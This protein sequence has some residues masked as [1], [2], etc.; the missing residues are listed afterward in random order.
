MLHNVDKQDC[1]VLHLTKMSQ[2]CIVTIS[3]DI[4]NAQ[5]AVL[6]P[7]GSLLDNHLAEKICSHHLE[8]PL[9]HCIKL[10][11]LVT[12]NEILS[13]YQSMLGKLQDFELF[14]K[15]WTLNPL[16]SKAC[17]YYEQFPLIMQKMTVLKLQMP[18][19]FKAS[20][21]NAYLSMAIAKRLGAKVDD[22][23]AVFLAGL[24][25]DIGVLHLDPELLNKK[26]AY[27]PEEWHNMQSHSVIA[28]NILQSIPGL[29]K[30]I[31]RAVLEH[32][33]RFDGSGYP[34]AKK[35][36]DLGIMGQIVGMADTCL[37]LYKRELAH[38]KLG[39]DALLPILQL[40]PDI[41]CRKVFSAM[42]ELIK[43]VSWPV[44]RVYSDE[45]IPAVISRL[46]LE[47]EGIQHD[48]TVLYGL[49]ASI[50]P[51]LPRNKR[52][53]MLTNMAQRIRQCLLSSGILQ[54]EHSQ[55]MA[56]SSAAQHQDDYLAIERL[57]IMYSEIKW[58]MLQ[59]KKMLFLLWKN[60]IFNHDDLHVLVQKG[61]WQ[62]EQF[63]KQQIPECV[64]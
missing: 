4:K 26:G 6:V 16:L 49:V 46:L 32:H 33:E 61:L 41:Y 28:F 10:D 5:G 21:M 34:L 30:S 1:Y 31:S 55:W 62:I 58:Q 53:A 39:F 3:D 48:Y 40:N 15:R 56:V 8:L 60:N 44:K 23:A 35:G 14:H 42:I 7:K 47:N 13:M 19:K 24:I 54:R 52:S 22:C 11:S 36:K 12:G 50:R 18:E 64:H 27:T 43:D 2:Q 37:A 20:L 45:K 59:L 63:H 29:P 51:H 9:E 57:E 17:Q 38:K 25:H